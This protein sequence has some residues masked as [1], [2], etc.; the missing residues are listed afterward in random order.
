MTFVISEFGTIW[1][2]ITKY[3]VVVLQM[4]QI[5]EPLVGHVICLGG[6]IILSQ[7]IWSEWITHMISRLRRCDNI[8]IHACCH[9]HGIF[10]RT[11]PYRIVPT[12]VRLTQLLLFF[13]DE[14]TTASTTLDLFE[15]LKNNLRYSWWLRGWKPGE[16]DFIIRITWRFY[17][18]E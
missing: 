3:L 5:L 1:Y 17:N 13:S 7:L 2:L 11:S 16:N 9:F 6:I 18:K 4:S 10:C 14:G 8:F 15:L 12:K